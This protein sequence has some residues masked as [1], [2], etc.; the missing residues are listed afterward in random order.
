[1]W[2]AY[3]PCAHAAHTLVAAFGILPGPQ[4]ST[5]VFRSEYL[6]FALVQHLVLPAEHL[7]SHPGPAEHD[8]NSTQSCVTPI[9]R[10]KLAAGQ[11]ASH[12]CVL[13]SA[14]FP[15]GHSWHSRVTS[16]VFPGPHFA[17]DPIVTVSLDD[18][19]TET[20]STAWPARARCVG[21][22]LLVDCIS[23]LPRWAFSHA[24]VSFVVGE[25]S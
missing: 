10:A 13:W 2:S 11:A 12:L 24:R 6:A 3:F 14:N 23:G 20:A 8:G 9:G 19:S 1:M 4:L 17:A 25:L 22:A 5:Q 16:G 21:T 15:A 18:S 7:S